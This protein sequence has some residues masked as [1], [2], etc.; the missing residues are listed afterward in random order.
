MSDARLPGCRG[1]MICLLGS[2]TVFSRSRKILG[3]Y[4]VKPSVSAD[5]AAERSFATGCHNRQLWCC[6]VDRKV[7]A[8]DGVYTKIWK[9]SHKDSK[10]PE[11]LSSRNQF[12]AD[13]NKLIQ[14]QELESAFF[15]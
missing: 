12:H 2:Y 3:S 7:S 15:E 11:A 14:M 4:M 5:P 8:E 13:W 6:K 1:R 10:A 9:E